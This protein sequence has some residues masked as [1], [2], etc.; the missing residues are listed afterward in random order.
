MMVVTVTEWCNNMV[1]QPNP[2]QNS[3][4]WNNNA[5]VDEDYADY[6]NTMLIKMI[7]MSNNYA[8]LL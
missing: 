2:G 7:L 4:M 5:D 6:M 8:I 3:E 1:I